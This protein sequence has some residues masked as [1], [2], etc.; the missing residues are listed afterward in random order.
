M[1][2]QNVCRFNKYGY[3][4]YKE[5]CRKLHVNEKCENSECEIKLCMKRHPKICKFYRDYNY[6]KFGEFCKFVHIMQNFQVSHSENEKIQ[7]KL[8]EIDAQLEHLKKLEEEI[9]KDKI[10][11]EQLTQLEGKLDYFLNLEKNIN[12]KYELIANLTRKVSDMEE[13]L[14]LFENHTKLVTFKC[15]ECE[16]STT[17]EKGL[18]THNKRMHIKQKLRKSALHSQS[19]VIFV[20]KKSKVI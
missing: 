3:C 9:L 19:N 11:K 12:E 7:K 18:K 2:T 10:S 20:K 6:C 4:R 1:A 15:N 17:S 5:K 16:F 14:N 8:S 13:K